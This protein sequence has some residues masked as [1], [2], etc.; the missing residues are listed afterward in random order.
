M[1]S[2]EGDKA[3]ILNSNQDNWDK[4]APLFVD[5]SSLPVWGPLGVGDDLG[6][7]PKIEGQ[8]FLEI[9]C[10]SGRSIKYLTD[11]GAKKIYGLDLSKKQVAESK[12]FNSEAIANGIVEILSLIHI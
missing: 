6:L 2:V 12:S 10:G 11:H 1:K 8:V 3:K 9:A 7:I 5:A 4:A